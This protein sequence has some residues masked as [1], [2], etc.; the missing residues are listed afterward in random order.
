MGKLIKHQDFKRFKICKHLSFDQDL[1]SSE[2][3][4]THEEAFLE[5]EKIWHSLLLASQEKIQKPSS[6]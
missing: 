1:S 4:K 6:K 5:S 2:E 3:V